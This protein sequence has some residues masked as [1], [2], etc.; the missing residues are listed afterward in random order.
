M[1][2]GAEPPLGADAAQLADGHALRRLGIDRWSSGD[3]VVSRES[4][5][6]EAEVERRIDATEHLIGK[7]MVLKRSWPDSFPI[8]VVIPGSVIPGTK[9]R[10]KPTC[11]RVF[12]R[13]VMVV[14]LL[15]RPTKIGSGTEEDRQW[16]ILLGW[17]SRWRRRTYVSWTR[18]GV[19]AHEVKVQ[20]TPEAG[21][22]L[23]WPRRQRVVGWCS[24]QVEWRRCSTTV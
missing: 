22:R 6:D 4:P 18:E 17:T 11:E 15:W 2:L 19:I 16:T 20:T 23:R 13:G 1:D 24:R 5:A 3:T 8:I 9:S 12:Q 10:D 7:H 21:S 14:A